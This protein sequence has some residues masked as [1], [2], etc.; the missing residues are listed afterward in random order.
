MKPSFV[1]ILA[2]ESALAKDRQAMRSS[3]FLFLKAQFKTKVTFK[4]LCQKINL[5]PKLKISL[6]R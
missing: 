3:L 1:N 2:V 6:I 4:H 5:F